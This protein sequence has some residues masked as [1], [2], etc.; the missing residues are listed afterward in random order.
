M[1][2]SLSDEAVVNQ[3]QDER[4]ANKAAKRTTSTKPDEANL[5]LLSNAMLS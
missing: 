1:L 2:V 4:D 5:Q 3:V